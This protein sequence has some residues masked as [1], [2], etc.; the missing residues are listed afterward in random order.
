MNGF[1][2]TTRSGSA[3]TLSLAA[4][5]LGVFLFCPVF[6]GA[7]PTKEFDDK[8]PGL[9]RAI[10]GQ[11]EC[12]TPDG[13]LTPVLNS[14][15]HDSD[16]PALLTADNTISCDLQEGETVFIIPFPK[17]A[18]LDRFTFVNQNAAASGEFNIA[19]SDSRLSP[20]SPKWV[21]VDGIVPFSHKRLFNLSLLGTEAKYLKLSFHV[22][23]ASRLT[24]RFN[25]ADAER[26][27]IAAEAL[28]PASGPAD[29]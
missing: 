29:D 19:I 12:I 1:L 6:T 3:A 22:E 21:Q 24:R 25:P 9:D 2:F 11:I 28:P 5:T 26:S 27:R 7:A 15:A 4:L 13:R 10:S 18:L 16:A 14:S 8:D 20:D 17:A 23:K